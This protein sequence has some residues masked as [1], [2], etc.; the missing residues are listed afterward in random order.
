MNSHSGS[1]RLSALFLAIVFLCGICGFCFLNLGKWLIVSDSPDDH[2]NVIFTFAGEN[3]RITYSKYLFR[4]NPESLWIISYPSIKIK[5]VLNH[6]NLDTS[7]IIV[8]DTCTDTKAEVAYILRWQRLHARLL[9]L[10]A[11]SGRTPVIGLVSS[12][13][14]MRRIKLLFDS[15]SKNESCSVRFLPV[16]INDSTENKPENTWWKNSTNRHIVL[17]EWGKLLYLYCSRAFK[18]S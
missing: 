16:Q 7:R 1:V 11:V 12:W 10:K 9:T 15:Q 4:K 17:S 13:Y 8:V 2:M 14:H 18:Q 3:A 5:S 6:D